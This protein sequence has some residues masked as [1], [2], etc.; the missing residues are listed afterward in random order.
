LSRRL[1]WTGRVILA[2]GLVTAA[3]V[4][5]MGWRNKELRNDPSMLG[6]NRAEQRQMGELYGQS[7]LLM[8]EWMNDLKRPGTQAGLIL[9][10]SGLV[11]AGCFYLARLVA[12]DGGQAG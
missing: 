6:F 5:G 11:A 4:Y 3:W 12:W 9:V 2:A 10:S 7:G 1:K 8:D